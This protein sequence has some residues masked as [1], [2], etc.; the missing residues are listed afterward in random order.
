MSDE[1]P[2]MRRSEALFV[3]MCIG[4]IAFVITFLLPFFSSQRVAWYYPLQH[5]WAYEVK[6][7][8]LAMDFY[9]RLM[10]ALGVGSV[11]VTLSI[12]V[13]RRFQDLG[14]GL[15]RLLILWTTTVVLFAAAYFA[16][17]LGHRHPTPEPVPSWYSPR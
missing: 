3:A 8:G 11:A 1:R 12:V 5:R 16:W 10:F 13:A 2:K 6:P 15:R 9:G 17:T 14:E 4:T 7:H